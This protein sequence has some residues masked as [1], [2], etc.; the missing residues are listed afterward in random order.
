MSLYDYLK[1]K[2]I[3]TTDPTF[4]SLIMAAAKKARTV[5]FNKLKIAFPR[6]V[7]EFEKREHANRLG[8][9]DGDEMVI[10]IDG[11]KIKK[12]FRKNI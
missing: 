10:E 7:G 4:S 2:E 12:I 6:L 9:L 3:L 1:S 11:K 8:L 5:S